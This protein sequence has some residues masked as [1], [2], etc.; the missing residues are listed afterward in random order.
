MAVGNDQQENT[1]IGGLR[2][3][4]FVSALTD[5]LETIRERHRGKMD[6]SP[7]K[8]MQEQAMLLLLANGACLALNELKRE[9]ER[10]HEVALERLR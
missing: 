3:K 2:D 7:K 9:I 6:A 10:L 5:T 1:L 8:T 4:A